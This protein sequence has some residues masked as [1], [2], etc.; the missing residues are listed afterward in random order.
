VTELAVLNIDENDA[1]R[2]RIH[3]LFAQLVCASTRLRYVQEDSMDVDN[4][5]RG[6]D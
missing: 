4:L 2:L 1:R 5:A 3:G 6:S